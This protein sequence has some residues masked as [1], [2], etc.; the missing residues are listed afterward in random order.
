[1]QSRP[2]RRHCMHCH[3]GWQ[4]KYQKKAFLDCLAQK[5]EISKEIYVKILKDYN[6][7]PTNPLAQSE[8]RMEHLFDLAKMVYADSIEDEIGVRL[9]KGIAIGLG[10]SS[11][12][13]EIVRK[14][15]VIVAD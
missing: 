10:Y 8:K 9:L 14:A 15:L 5:L 1:M 12:P 11:K 3:E 2:L 7:Y 4:V 13:Q 6:G